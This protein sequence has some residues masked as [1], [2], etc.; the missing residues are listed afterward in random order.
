MELR[1]LSKDYGSP[2]PTDMALGKCKPVYE[3]L[4]GTAEKKPVGREEAV[5][6]IP[7]A[8]VECD[9]ATSPDEVR[10]ILWWWSGRYRSNHIVTAAAMDL[11]TAKGGR[12]GIAVAD[13]MAWSEAHERL[14]AAI[15][16]HNGAFFLMSPAYTAKAKIERLS[17]APTL[18][19]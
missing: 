14:L 12:Q 7:D 5:L 11:A 6:R 3:L 4:L 10:T 8:L 17:R 2:H 13:D 19:P 9:C 18:C 15:D 16:K 1:K